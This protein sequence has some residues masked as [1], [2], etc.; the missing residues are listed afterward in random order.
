MPN[1]SPI[2]ADDYSPS[3]RYFIA[4]LVPHVFRGYRQDDVTSSTGTFLSQALALRFHHILHLLTTENLVLSFYHDML[5]ILFVGILRLDSPSEWPPLYG[6]IMQAYTVR[7]FW[8][9]H[10]HLLIYR[11]FSGL[12]GL[13]L[14]QVGLS[15][16]RAKVR[17]ARLLHNGLV[18]VASGLMHVMVQWVQSEGECWRCGC[19][20]IFRWFVLQITG[21]TIEEVVLDSV[22]WLLKRNSELLFHWGVSEWFVR[23]AGRVVGYL[24]VLSWLKWTTEATEFPSLHCNMVS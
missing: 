17:A 8:S 20:G 1:D 12:I 11:S 14:K 21:I 2:I 6:N 18:F 3:N 13:A 9:K 5:A 7:R 23:R 22:R 10:W 4:T 24:W 15:K 19:W 16:Q